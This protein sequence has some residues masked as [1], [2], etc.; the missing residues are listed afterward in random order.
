MLRYEKIKSYILENLTVSEIAKK[1]GVSKNTIFR[2]LKKFGIKTKTGSQGARKH[3]F[4][5]S[6]FKKINSEEKAY[7]LGFI[8]ADGC[9]YS[10]SD[11]YSMRLQI[12]LKGSEKSH[13]DK[14]QKAIGSD[15]KISEKKVKVYD[16]CQLKVNSTIMCKDLVKLGIVKR[17]SL[18]VQM[19]KINKKL[20]RHYV[21]GYFDGD[22]CITH[23]FDKN[24]RHRRTFSIV[25]GEDMLVKILKEIPCDIK[26]HKLKRVSDIFEISTTKEENFSIIYDYLYKNST[27]FLERKKNSF[28]DLLS[29]FAEMQRQ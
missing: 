11:K 28:E 17:K 25:G 29:R 8:A 10:G 3:K 9:V 20:I 16:V 4:E 7:W 24:G 18:T 15:Y 26:I 21:R 12:N 27:V 6:Y 2:D 19:P 5:E 1:I 14:F 13:L 23:G 22:G